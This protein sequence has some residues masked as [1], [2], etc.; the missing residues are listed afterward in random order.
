MIV[1]VT[2]RTFN[3][4]MYEPKGPPKQ[5]RQNVNTRSYSLGTIPLCNSYSVRI[6]QSDCLIES[7]VR[8]R[9]KKSGMGVL[10]FRRSDVLFSGQRPGITVMEKSRIDKP[11]Q[12]SPNRRT[13]RPRGQLIFA[14]PLIPCGISPSESPISALAQGDT[15]SAM[16]GKPLSCLARIKRNEGHRIEAARNRAARQ[17]LSP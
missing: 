15:E 7:Q 9:F 14:R 12:S 4:W 2:P 1:I 3:R 17:R 8:N 5:A 13:A 10:R 11:R 6:H 16:A